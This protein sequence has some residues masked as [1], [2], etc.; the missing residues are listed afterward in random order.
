MKGGWK[1]DT[2]KT[3]NGKRTTPMPRAIGEEL[4][5]Y[6]AQHPYRDDPNAAL[7]PGRTPGTMGDPRG[8]D[9]D[10]RFDIASLIGYYFKPALRELGLTAIRWH[11]L[12]HFYETVMISQIGKGA[13]YSL[14]EVSRYMGHASYQTTVDVYGHRLEV[15]PNVD[16]FGDVT[17]AADAETGIV[18]PLRAAV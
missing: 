4:A 16:V 17:A 8:V 18:A 15:R 2:P 13:Q 1:I 3:E 5:S 11:D 9:Y 7:W 10:R 14:Y 12:R 6:L